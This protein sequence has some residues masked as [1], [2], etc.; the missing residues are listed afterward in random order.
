MWRKRGSLRT[1]N[2]EDLGRLMSVTILSFFVEE[3]IK[4]Y[5]VAMHEQKNETSGYELEA[6]HEIWHIAGLDRNP[7]AEND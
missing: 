6:R 4:Y 5:D 7:V 2:W 1:S 3:I